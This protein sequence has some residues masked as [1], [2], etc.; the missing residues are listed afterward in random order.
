[1]CKND[2]AARK[3]RYPCHLSQ[4]E[5]EMREIRAKCEDGCEAYAGN[6]ESADRDSHVYWFCCISTE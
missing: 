5:N 2:P 4:I 3:C 6:T 1:M